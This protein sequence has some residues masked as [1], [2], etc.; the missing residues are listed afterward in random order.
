MAV[1]GNY[2]GVM[3]GTSMAAPTVAGIIALWLQAKPTLS[4]SEIKNVLALT[5]AKDKYT[6][7][8]QFGP[9]GKIDAFAGMYY[10]LYK[11]GL[12]KGDVNNDGEV[13]IAD[14]NTL[15]DIIL[16][17]STG[18]PRP[19]VNRDGEVKIADVNTIIVLLL[20]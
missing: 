3:S 16:T 6:L 14:V 19:D 10:V 17:D 9:N 12:I 18:N 7:T 11:H 13:N 1:D 15:I 5:A 20:S 8:P 2:W 4:V